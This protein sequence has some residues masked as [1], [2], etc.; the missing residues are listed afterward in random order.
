MNGFPLRENDERGN[1]QLSV[2]PSPPV[3]LQPS[4]HPRVAGIHYPGE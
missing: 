2:I 3:I 1:T 4:R